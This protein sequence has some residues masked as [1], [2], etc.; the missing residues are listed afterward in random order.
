MNLTDTA[1]FQ[2]D[3]Q[4]GLALPS[5]YVSPA[6]YRICV[7][8]RV[9]ALLLDQGELRPDQLD[10]I[11][12][13]L[14]GPGWRDGNEDGSRYVWRDLKVRRLSSAEREA[15]EYVK[16]D[17]AFRY[18]HCELKEDGSLHKTTLEAL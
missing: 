8:L 16:E 1:L 18:W 12:A 6:S 5:G 7:Y 14:Y 11:F 17:P 9:P 3:F 10:L 4:D 2:V 15:R 13:Y